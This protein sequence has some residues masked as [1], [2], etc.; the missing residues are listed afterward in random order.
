MNCHTA[1]GVVAPWCVRSIVEMLRVDC[2]MCFTERLHPRSI[3]REPIAALPVV[4]ICD[5]DFGD[6]VYEHSETYMSLARATDTREPVIAPDTDGSSDFDIG[7]R[8]TMYDKFM[9]AFKYSQGPFL[10]EEDF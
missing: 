9:D 3:W 8:L 1:R 5:K 4:G 10:V 6:S 7:C 2:S